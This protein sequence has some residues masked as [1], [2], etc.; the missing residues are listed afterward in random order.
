MYLRCMKDVKGGRNGDARIPRLFF[1]FLTKP[2][3]V[4]GKPHPHSSML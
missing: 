2:L 1:F 3:E 4:W